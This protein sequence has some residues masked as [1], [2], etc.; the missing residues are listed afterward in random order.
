MDVI[1]VA[2]GPTNEGATAPIGE[3]EL[4]LIDVEPGFGRDA[5]QFTIS[6]ILPIVGCPIEIA[7]DRRFGLDQSGYICDLIMDEVETIQNNH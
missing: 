7:S 3:V 5:N 6:M 2:S 1:G 4:K